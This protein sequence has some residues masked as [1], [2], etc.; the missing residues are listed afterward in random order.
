M[1]TDC[2]C[3]PGARGPDVPACAVHGALVCI[4]CGV[5]EFV[6]EHGQ[7]ATMGHDCAAH[8]RA[9]LE[10]GVLSLA[11]ERDALRAQL[12]AAEDER[13]GARALLALTRECLRSAEDERDDARALL[14]DALRCGLDEA[15][16]LRGTVDHVHYWYSTRWERLRVLLKGTKWMD[17]ACSVMANGTADHYEPPTYAQLLN[18]ERHRAEAAERESARLRD[19]LAT[20]T[21]DFLAGDAECADAVASRNEEHAARVAAEARVA[22]LRGALERLACHACDEHPHRATHVHADATRCSATTARGASRAR[23]GLRR[24]PPTSR[25]RP[26]T[27]PRGALDRRPCPLPDYVR[28]SLPTTRLPTLPLRIVR[29]RRC[30]DARADRRGVERQRDRRRRGESPARP[31]TPRV[32]RR[33]RRRRCARVHRG[34]G[35]LRAEGPR[36]RHARCRPARA[37][38]RG[39]RGVSVLLQLGAVRL[40]VRRGESTARLL[41]WIRVA[42]R[43]RLAVVA[44][45]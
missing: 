35:L 37:R 16:R 43:L 36:D 39:A 2:T 17:R 10:C 40:V 5:R 14:A 25:V 3:P 15:E 44:N 18:I 29:S 33:G 20:L 31:S 23:C 13:D 27:Q 42:R 24:S 30:V 12:A 8:R 22:T 1:A 41:R 45:G 19:E 26:A 6:G 4:L 34:G 28:S 21:A 9:Q 32:R 11:T 38:Q 7:Y